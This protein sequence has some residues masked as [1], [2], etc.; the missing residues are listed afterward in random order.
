MKNQNFNTAAYIAQMRR[1][2]IGILVLC[3]LFL[4]PLLQAAPAA[5]PQLPAPVPEMPQTG[6]KPL[7]V[8]ASPGTAGFTLPATS[9]EPI[10]VYRRNI[11]MLA[12]Q[13]PIPLLQVFADGRVKVHFPEYMKN[14]GD[15]E[16]QLSRAELIALVRG[17][18]SHGV[19]DFDRQRV[20]HEKQMHDHKLKQEKGEL[21]Y[22]SDSLETVVDIRL[23]NYQKSATAAKQ[24][25]FQ[26][27]FS[28]K[29]LEHDARRYKNN[30]T[31][32]SAAT[33]IQ[34]LDKLLRHQAMR[35]VK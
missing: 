14:A 24:A 5:K 29:N 19:M 16:Y 17:L 13:D 20:Q 33:A 35:K 12:N 25:N 3:G 10:I 27:R 21:H 6:L 22:I 26:Q 28:W 32:Q 11:S 18:S 1:T 8:N 7:A 4:S 9:S 23:Q 30:R 34:E 15:Y 31:I 2:G